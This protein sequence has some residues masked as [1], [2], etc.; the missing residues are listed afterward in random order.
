MEGRSRKECVSRREGG[1]KNGGSVPVGGKADS[2]ETGRK[3]RE[4]R[5]REMIMKWREKEVEKWMRW[6]KET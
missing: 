1:R 4:K 2:H 6:R 5:E 3:K